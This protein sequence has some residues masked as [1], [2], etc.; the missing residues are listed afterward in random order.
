MHNILGIAGTHL[1]QFIAA[2]SALLALTSQAGTAVQ[3]P[4]FFSDHM[5]LQTGRPV[6]VWG[7]ADPKEKITVS[8][9][10]QTKTT[11]AGQDGKWSVKLDPMQP[12]GPLTL[13]VQSGDAGKRTINDVLVGEVWLCS[14]Q[15]NMALTVNKAMNYEKEQPLAT[16]PKIRTM[17]NNKWVVCSPE[18]VG[19]FSAAA[20]FFGREIHKKTGLPVGLLNV[21]SGGTPIELWTSLEAQKAV[22]ELKPLFESSGEAAVASKEDAEQANSDR[23][24]AAEVEGKKAVAGQ[25]VAPGYLFNGRILPLAPYAI[26]GAIW[27]QGEANSYTVNANL[28][29][30]Q[31]AT[32]IKDWR[33]RWGFDFAFITVQLPD[34]GSAQTEPVQ[35]HGRV[36]VREGVLKSLSVPNTGMAVTIGTGEEKSN[37]P[38]NK[39]EVGRRLAQWALAKVY[40]Q[41]DVAG[42][43][44]L[45]ESSKV[46]DGKIVVTFSHADGG[47]VAQ[48]GGELKGFAIAGADMKWVWGRATI[49]GKTVIVS[50]P[51]VKEP[52]AVRYAWALNPAS[53]NLFNGAGL[54]ATPFRTDNEPLSN[55]H[56]H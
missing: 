54:P 3:L 24:Q 44:P 49:D 23:N 19:T 14:G 37:H 34:I 4:S 43:G 15:S 50:S 12:G 25:K 39:Q 42:S 36:L 51:E 33:S 38:K 6:P 56:M 1:L 7:K 16:W 28:Y 52:V 13:T 27:Y 45:P 5:V 47:L 46:V 2:I 9:G 40:E 29:G 30:I 17:Q 41:K 32:M 21:S 31:L 26:R 48:G 35:T 55:A 20:Y 8:I 53:S 22:P 10:D 11:E 18:T